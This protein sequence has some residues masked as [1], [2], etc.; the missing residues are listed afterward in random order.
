[1]DRWSAR[2]PHSREDEARISKVQGLRGARRHLPNASLSPTEITQ[3]GPWV[4]RETLYNAIA[5]QDYAQGGR[6]NVVEESDS[7]LF[8]NLGEFLPGS[9]EK[10]IREDAPPE[11]YRNRFMA[12]A[13]VNLNMIDTIGSGIKRMFT[14]QRQRSFPMP[15]YDLGERGRVKV[16]I[17]GTVVDEK[18]TRLL[19]P[20]RTST[21]CLWTGFQI[22]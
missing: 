1:V 9:V 5:H 2:N 11:L 18:Y 22:I 6:I 7:L 14:K 8:T 21:N 15:D 16:R 17:I 10:V 12:E 19:N 20:G 4:I 13:M 3:Y